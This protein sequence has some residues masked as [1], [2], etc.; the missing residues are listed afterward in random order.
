MSC[1]VSVSYSIKIVGD[2]G[3]GVWELKD[4]HTIRPVQLLLGTEYRVYRYRVQTVPG[5]YP[6]IIYASG[7]GVVLL[8]IFS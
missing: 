8:V 1:R 4:A 6:G 2:V 3:V 7:A 5:W